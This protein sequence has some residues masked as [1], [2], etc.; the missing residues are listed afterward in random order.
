MSCHLPPYTQQ[1]PYCLRP[2]HLVKEAAGALQH[3]LQLNELVVGACQA[4]AVAVDLHDFCF[5][6]LQL[7]LLVVN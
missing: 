1:A 5:Q 3:Q 2:P 6:L 4:L 7:A